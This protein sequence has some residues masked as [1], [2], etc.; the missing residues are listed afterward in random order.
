M[1]DNFD[2][3]VVGAG[4]AGCV[5]AN[6]LTEGGKFT[7]LLI[8]AGG[9]DRRFWINV[10]IG[11][12][13][14]FYDNNVN[15]RYL[16]E[17]DPGISGRQEYWPRGKVVGGSSSINAMVYIRG[18]HEDYE[19][20]AA[21]GNRGWG[22]KDVLPYFMKSEGN[23]RGSDAFHNATGPLAVSDFQPHPLN[24]PFFEGLAELGLKPNPD[25]NGKVQEGYGFYQLTTRNG[26]RS[27]SSKAFLYP[28][29]KR[30]NVTLEINS[31][32]ERID[33]E[34]KRAVGV[35]YR[36]NG[37]SFSARAKKEVILSAGAVNSPQI[38]QLSGVG[39]AD[40][41]RRHGIAVVHDLPGVGRNLQDHI[42]VPFVFEANRPTIN[43][44]LKS[45][46]GKL[47]AGMKY[48]FARQGPLAQ[49][50]N[51]GGGFFRSRSNLKRPNMQIYFNAASVAPR[52]DAN[53]M[54]PLS[55]SSFSGFGINLSP[56]RPTSR[57]HIEI[58]SKNPAEAPAI[59]PNYLSTN[60]DIEEVLEGVRWVRRLLSSKSLANLIKREVT[61]WPEDGTDSSAIKYIRD[62]SKT[63]YHPT[64]T[65]MMG[66]NPA[67]AVV[68]ERLRVYGLQNLRVVDAS[69]FPSMISG[70]TNAT[71][72]M[73]GEKGAAMILED[74]VNAAI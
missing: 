23:V 46:H 25:F 49:S 31:L 53:D 69:I 15:W 10:P 17:P 24:D 73:V 63:C 22:F 48:I 36:K 35:T 50:I 43:N 30:G 39:P 21:A 8:E 57:G 38:L 56:C 1:T 41:L 11:Y 20:W 58:K 16:A 18:Q 34:G 65:C 29:L 66:P 40:L 68:D 44:E 14:T 45:W 2:F 72:I 26:V 42:F 47:W 4:S 71:A 74:Q 13:K 51:Q 64:S 12:G 27:S 52:K 32:T 54:S 61:S 6:R 9:S 7:V 55:L 5:L 33:F 28:A 70:N 37:K 19:D 59:H 60:S 3:I 62:T 67:N